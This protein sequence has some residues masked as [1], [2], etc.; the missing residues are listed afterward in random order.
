MS[1][2]RRD[3]DI[4]EFVNTLP[5]SSTSKPIV[6][7]RLILLATA[8]GTIRHVPRE[9]LG[10]SWSWFSM[11]SARNHL[12]RSTCLSGTIATQTSWP[13]WC[14]FTVAAERRFLF[15]I[16]R[17]VNENLFFMALNWD[18]EPQSIAESD[19]R[20]ED[21]RH[22]VSGEHPHR[23]TVFLLWLRAHSIC[24]REKVFVMLHFQILFVCREQI[25][26]RHVVLGVCKQVLRGTC[27]MTMTTDRRVQ[28]ENGF[29]QTTSGATKVPRAMIHDIFPASRQG[30]GWSSRA[31]VHGKHEIQVSSSTEPE[32][33]VELE[34]WD[35]EGGWLVAEWESWAA[36]PRWAGALTTACGQH[37]RWQG[38]IMFGCLGESDQKTQQ[39][40][41]RNEQ[42]AQG[43]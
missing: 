19:D 26:K 12:G 2:W 18:T 22:T 29:K 35:R 7:L 21:W 6:I 9:R 10:R 39:W 16:V 40:E 42:G 34:W 13:H 28:V 27:D 31:D 20:R 14:F 4:R 25:L 24:Q 3:V 17:D 32:I 43:E 38:G 30:D 1:S 36:R 33:Q 15:T 11:C 5:T 41:R 8:H 37:S 23:A